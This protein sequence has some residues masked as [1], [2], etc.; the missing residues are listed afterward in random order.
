MTRDY[1]I[2]DLAAEYALG[3]L[4]AAERA[5]VEIRRAIE[6]DLAAA[7]VAVERDLAPLIGLV[8]DVEPP[9]NIRTR[10]LATIAGL[11]SRSPVASQSAADGVEPGTANI[12]AIRPSELLNRGVGDRDTVIELAHA[13][14]EIAALHG[15]V[16]RWRVLTA[17]VSTLAASL[18]GLVMYR[19]TLVRVPEAAPQTFVAVLQKDAQ[20]PAFLMTVD[21]G[22]RQFTVRPVS[23]KQP[24][25]KSYELWIIHDTL[26][27]PKSLGLLADN[28]PR[29]SVSLAAFDTRA[30][31]GATYAVTVEPS[32]GSPTGAP[33]G[34]PVF[35]GKL[36]PAGLK[37]D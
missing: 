25:G 32:G 34:A 8:P 36:L 26:N 14:E 24:A 18:A 17:G 16:S 13:R 30:I 33:S 10:L 27:A 35:V 9:A 22:K 19:D 21:V 7:I 5:E 4:D 23:A 1:D 37:A 29:A 20:S 31:S 11:G 6:P 15:R 12:G 28:A 2:S 3:T